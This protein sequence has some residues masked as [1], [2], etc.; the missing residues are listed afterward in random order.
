MPPLEPRCA[1]GAD[2]RIHLPTYPGVNP[3]PV[4]ALDMD[5]SSIWISPRLLGTLRLHPMSTLT[6]PLEK[7]HA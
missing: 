4:A 6:P 5:S 1:E 3:D 7:S 2:R